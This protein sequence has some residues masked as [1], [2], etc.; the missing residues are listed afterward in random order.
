MNMLYL[1]PP[2]PPAL[3]APRA[4]PAVLHVRRT[5]PNHHARVIYSELYP[6]IITHATHR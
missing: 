3:R 4:R 1:H 6:G 5:N 2:P